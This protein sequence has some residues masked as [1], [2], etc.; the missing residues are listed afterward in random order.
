M[1]STADRNRMSSMDGVIALRKIIRSL[2]LWES[3]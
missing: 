3:H 2:S 1:S